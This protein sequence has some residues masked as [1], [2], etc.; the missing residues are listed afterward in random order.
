MNLNTTRVLKVCTLHCN[1]HY[2]IMT[3][4]NFLYEFRIFTM[5]LSI[6]KKQ[7]CTI[8]TFGISVYVNVWIETSNNNKNTH[9]NIKLSL[10]CVYDKGNHKCRLSCNAPVI[11]Q[12]YPAC[13]NENCSP[14]TA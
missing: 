11:L 8:Q 9:M 10:E 13:K 6:P 5:F 7:C 1:N 12:K 14:W 3:I 4:M 2:E